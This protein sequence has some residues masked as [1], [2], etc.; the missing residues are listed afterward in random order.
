MSKNIKLHVSETD[1]GVRLDKY[2]TEKIDDLSRAKVL[3]LIRDS[4][5]LVNHNKVNP[6]YRV[7]S[8]ETIEITIR[9][10]AISNLDPWQLKLEIVY[11]DEYIL[12][13]NKPSGIAVHP[14][15]GHRDKTIANALINHDPNI[16]GIGTKSRPGIIHRLDMETSG[17]LVT[18]KTELAHRKVSQQFADRNVQKTYLAVVNGIPKELQAVI[19]A[20]IGR[21]P[22]NRQH[23]D[24]VS[25]GKTAVTQYE[26]IETYTDHSLLKVFP[27]TGRTHQI[28][29]HLKS[30]G[31]SVLGDQTYGKP[32]IGLGRQFLHASSLTFNH[33][34]SEKLLTFNL[35]LPLE[36]SQY[37]E[38]LKSAGNMK[39]TA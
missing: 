25:T 26:V 11:E 30:I 7:K 9:N 2:V 13:I 28:R 12:V 22:F 37:L 14:A 5:V 34:I 10:D 24:I 8:G 17:L 38:S 21:S 18:A 19:D 23:M 16:S 4:S 20:P 31:H 27:K 36:L 32:E 6:S 33:P 39:D 35:D 29:V 1:Q 3:K 15:P